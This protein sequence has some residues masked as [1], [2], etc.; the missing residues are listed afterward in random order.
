[1]A[2]LHYMTNSQGC[3][4]EMTEESSNILCG[5]VDDR[6]KLFNNRNPLVPDAEDIVNLLLNVSSM[7]PRISDFVHDRV[8]SCAFRMQLRKLVAADP[9]I[10]LLYLNR[11][12]NSLDSQEEL[13]RT[14]AV[15]LLYVAPAF[16]KGRH[17][18]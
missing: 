16:V 3:V 8:N 12:I 11:S 14:I 18:S 15:R 1:M 10:Q 5:P 4:S 2:K 17:S 7:R 9:P 6:G 13:N